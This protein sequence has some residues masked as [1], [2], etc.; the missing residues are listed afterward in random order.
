MIEAEVKLKIDNIEEIRKKLVSM[1]FSESFHGKECDRYFDDEKGNI[2][3]TD[4]ALRIREVTDLQTGQVICQ[5]NFKD[6]KSDDK[7]MTRP[8][9]ETQ[10][11]DF[12][13]MSHILQALGYHVVEPQVVKERYQYSK[14][15]INACLDQVEGLGSFLELEIMVARDEEKE[16]ALQRIEQTLDVLGC[17][18]EHTT[19]ISYLS[20]LQELQ[21]KI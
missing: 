16:A 5:I 10:V 1:G 7:T 14:E 17:T 8:E 2:R 13:E 12:A 15:D 3:G 9:Y 6:Q 20:Q 19:T 21:R 18:L 11:A 4:R